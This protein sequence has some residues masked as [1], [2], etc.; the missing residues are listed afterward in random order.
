MFMPSFKIRKAGF[1]LI[2][3]LVV[4]AIIAIL[5]GLLLPAV[6]KVREAA[7]KMKCQNNLKQLVLAL[8]GLND[9]R[10]ML[11]PLSAP[12]ADPVY[13]YC[14]TQPTSRYGAHVYTMFHFL[15]PYIEQKALFD[16]MSPSAEGGGNIG[17]VVNAYFC[18][19]DNSNLRGLCLTPNGAAWSWA[20]SS[21]AGNY[22]VFGNSA[23]PTPAG[24][25]LFP[26]SISDGT[27]NTIFFG[28]VFG[29]CGNSGAV[30][31]P[32]TTCNLWAD[33]NGSW[34]PGFNLG[35]NRSVTT[36]YPPAKMFQVN[37]HFLNSCDSTRLQSTHTGGIMVGF[38]DGAARFIN[39][40]ISFTTWATINDPRDGMVAGLDF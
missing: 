5:I 32:G 9:N 16:K 21:Y 17:A 7:A 28:E 23:I 4:I 20:N 31:G 36:G 34:R 26:E 10:G 1:T 40:T 8:H 19:S 25:N 35:M 27:A 12:C 38:G 39:Q 15:L 37:P 18:P 22:Y 2:E 3:L 33:A 24:E 14:I 11:P 6:Q 30:N 13:S 29:T